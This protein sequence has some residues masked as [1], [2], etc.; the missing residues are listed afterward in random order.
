M[1]LTVFHGSGLNDVPR[2]IS[3]SV[4]NQMDNCKPGRKN[5]M[6]TIR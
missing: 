3:L 6:F 1:K 2:S 4:L 5:P